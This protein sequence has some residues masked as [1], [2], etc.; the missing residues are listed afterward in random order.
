MCRKLYWNYFKRWYKQKY[1]KQF[2]RIVKTFVCIVTDCG[3]NRI[4]LPLGGT[5]YHRTYHVLQCS[6]CLW[7]LRVTKIH[8]RVCIIPAVSLHVRV[9]KRLQLLIKHNCIQNYYRL[10]PIYKDPALIVFTRFGGHNLVSLQSFST[11]TMN[12][13]FIRFFLFFIIF[14]CFPDHIFCMFPYNDASIMDSLCSRILVGAIRRKRR[15]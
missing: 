11:I 4:L 7:V 1:S 15:L 13:P 5:S 8:I 2:G 10:P 12:P 9:W 14:G 6:V 3:L